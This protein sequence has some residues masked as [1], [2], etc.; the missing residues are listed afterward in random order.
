MGQD[1]ANDYTRARRSVHEIS[2]GAGIAETLKLI[3]NPFEF[4]VPALLTHP[5]DV[6]PYWMLILHAAAITVTET[7][8]I[9]KSS[10]IRGIAWAA[11]AKG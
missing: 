4:L 11:S 6:R 1:F 10:D 8:R 2:A 7:L 9:T 3:G 5:N